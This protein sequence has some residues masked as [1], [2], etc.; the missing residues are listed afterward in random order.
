VPLKITNPLSGDFSCLK[1]CIKGLKVMVEEKTDFW[2][3]FI[4]TG[5]VPGE[6]TPTI[7]DSWKRCRDNNVNPAHVTEVDVL[8]LSELK[9]KI[10]ANQ[11]LISVSNPIMENVFEILRGMGIIVILSDFQGYILKCIVDEG[12]QKQ[13]KKVMLCEGVNWSEQLNGTN[14]IGT[15]L[16][17]QQPVKILGREHFIKKNHILACAASP[18]FDVNGQ[19][20]ATLDLTGEAKGSIDQI[21]RLVRMAARNIERELQFLHLQKQF[22]LHKAKHDSIVELIKEG[23]LFL[24]KEGTICEVNQAATKVLGI[25]NK[26]DFLGKNIQELFNVHN[27]W[28]F[29]YSKLDKSEL[30]ISSKSGSAMFSARANKICDSKGNLEG[31]VAI[32]DL[33]NRIE[34]R[35]VGEST[36]SKFLEHSSSIS[37]TFDKIIGKSEH[38]S[39][40]ISQ[41]K[42]VARSNSTVLLVGETGTGKEMLAQS[43]HQES[44]RRTHPFI[45]LNCAAI[46]AELLESELFGYEEGAF[47][48]ARKGGNPGKFE[49][50]NGGTLFLDEIGDMPFSAQ[51]SLLRVLQEKQVLRIGGRQSKQ[52]DVRI[53]AATHRNL[54]ELVNKGLFRQDLFFRLNVV[55]IYIPPLRERKEDIE[56]LARFFFDKFKT[57]MGRP[58]MELLPQTIKKFKEYSWPGNIREL[59]NTIEALV[60][61]VEED[62]ITPE[63]LPEGIMKELN[64]QIFT[65]KKKK[66]KDLEETAIKQALIDCNGDL[67]AVVSVLGI[68]RSTLYRKIKEYK[69]DVKALRK[70]KGMIG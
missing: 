5:E 15:S 2:E 57:E 9:E 18:I 62:I 36:S 25:K 7:R 35:R 37:Y 54:S 38:L 60:N 13:A 41:C 24:D 67:S 51:V 17:E 65:P 44:E 28:M 52:V 46:P 21:F 6:V 29:N 12:F 22:N 10:E 50:A 69:I 61:V 56:L 49:Q 27:I 45:G 40:V 26:N 55:S 19:L 23:V 33:D 63:H 32:V 39:R 70:G 43:I 68:G 1:N 48:G 30:T 3:S 34:K 16:V 4:E 31:V 66:L 20:L 8:T 64:G 47:T 14:A 42:R 59:K 11:E 58:T 53:I